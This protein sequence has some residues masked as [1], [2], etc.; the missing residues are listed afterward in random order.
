MDLVPVDADRAGG[1]L[2]LVTFLTV[3]VLPVNERAGS[4]QP[5]GRS[6]GSPVVQCVAVLPL[7]VIGVSIMISHGDR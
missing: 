1:E 5:R 2:G 6:M 7:G 4:L 3:A